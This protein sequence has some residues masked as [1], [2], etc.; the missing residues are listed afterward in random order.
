MKEFIQLRDGVIALIKRTQQQIFFAFSQTAPSTVASV[1]DVLQHD[2]ARLLDDLE[3]TRL[4]ALAEHRGPNATRLREQE[5]IE[6]AYL[7]ATA[8]RGNGVFVNNKAEAIIKALTPTIYGTWK[9]K[10]LNTALR[11]YVSFLSPEMINYWHPAPLKSTHEDLRIFKELGATKVKFIDRQKSGCV[12][13]T[14][15]EIRDNGFSWCGT[16][17]T[18]VLEQEEY[19][20]GAEYFN[21]EAFLELFINTVQKPEQP[22]PINLK[23]EIE[24]ILRAD[25]LPALFAQA[26]SAARTTYDDV[27][28][29]RHHYW[30]T[31]IDGVPHWTFK[32]FF[33][34]HGNYTG[35]QFNGIRG[36]VGQWFYL[37]R[38]WIRDQQ[39]VLHPHSHESILALFKEHRENFMRSVRDKHP[40]LFE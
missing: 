5:R 10:E 8:D 3:I 29:D 39:P 31:D 6:N 26:N 15:L 34:Q 40:Q 33:G 32:C 37:D 36:V 4:R 13:T 20:T 11:D 24:A 23:D 14:T 35:V 28:S 19:N 7:V 22:S 12:A 21:Q 9:P 27:R 30:E 25:P 18:D 17:A 1:I 38:N 2:S 16:H